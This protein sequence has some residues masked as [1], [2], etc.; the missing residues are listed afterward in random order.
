M[1]KLA[2]K[3]LPTVEGTSPPAPAA[4]RERLLDA[5]E[6]EITE[7]GSIDFSLRAIARR[8]NLSHQA[9][10]YAFGDRSGLL[11]ALAARGYTLADHAIRAARDEFATATARERLAEMGIAYVL[12]CAERPALLPLMSRSDL[13]DNTGELDRAKAGTR[14]ALLEA[15]AAARAEGWNAQEPAHAVA[16]TCW[17]LVHGFAVL[18]GPGGVDDLANAPLETLARSAMRQYLG[19]TAH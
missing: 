9:P 6:A 2:A 3:P 17:A 12:A 15:V 18:H 11:T 7:T 14:D 5:A 16:A 8:A 1:A 10:G 13:A 4:L 19:V